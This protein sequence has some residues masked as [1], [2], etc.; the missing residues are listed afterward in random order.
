MEDKQKVTLYLPSELHRQLKISSVVQQETMSALAE[1]AIEFYLEHAEL[2]AEADANRHGEAHRVYSCPEC[3][4]ALVVRGNELA[5][6][7]NQPTVID[8]EGLTV[9]TLPTELVAAR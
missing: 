8:D 9:P 4:S 3:A 2:V 7:A 6:L 5:S 1:R